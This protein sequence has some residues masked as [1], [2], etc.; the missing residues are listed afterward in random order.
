MKTKFKEWW[1]KRLVT[2]KRHPNY[3]PLTM[4]IIC[5]LVY[6]LNLTKMSDTIAMV[7]EPGMGICFFI[8]VLCSFLSLITYLTSYPSRKP[9]KESSIILVIAMQIISIICDF[10]FRY[11][12]IYGTVIKENPIEITAG[13]KYIIIAKNISVVHMILVSIAI[14]LIILLPVYRKKLQKIDTSIKLEDVEIKS[15][16]ITKEI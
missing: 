12:I 8:I 15:I 1:R 4:L 5:C 13:R 16:D 7:N 10:I 3:I 2:L 14:L 9:P 6:N 11:F